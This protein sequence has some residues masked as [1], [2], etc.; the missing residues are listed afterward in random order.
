MKIETAI[1]QI[2]LQAD[3]LGMSFIDTV[4][5]LKKEPTAFPLKSIEALKVLKRVKLVKD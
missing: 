2:E 4:E 5:L 1:K 3:F